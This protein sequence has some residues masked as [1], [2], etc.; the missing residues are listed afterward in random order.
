MSNI[1]YSADGKTLIKCPEDYQGT[2]QIPD[3][4]TTIGEG[5]FKDCTSLTSIKI[6]DSVTEIGFVAF[7]D[8][9]ALTSIKIPDSVIEIGW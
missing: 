7:C 5:A 4:V 3:S 9:T 6:P 1:K 2:F 8:C